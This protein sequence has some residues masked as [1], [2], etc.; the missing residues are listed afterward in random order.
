V[1]NS[2]V[3]TSFLSADHR[4]ALEHLLFF[5]V[6]QHRVL[7]GIQESIQN[8]GVPEIVEE[9]GH[10]RIAVG[11][12]RD[13][14]TLFAVSPQGWP[15]GFV[16]FAQLARSRFV[17]LHLGIEPRLRSRFDVNTPVL[18]ELLR[19]VRS[20]ARSMQGVERIEMVYNPRRVVRLPRELPQP[21]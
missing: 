2:Y 10:L 15:L 17:V 3:I 5:N 14:R 18:L 8:Y 4:R 11:D 12:L 16:V 9:Q 21:I 20:M 1:A 6:N 19:E 13:V 7:E